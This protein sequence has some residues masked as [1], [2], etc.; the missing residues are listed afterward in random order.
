MPLTDPL[1]DP[2]QTG[3]VWFSSTGHTLRR[4][5]LDYWN[6]Y[7]GLAQ[8]G[9][10]LTE[11]FFES[12]GADNKLYLVQYFERSRFEMHSEN[13]GTRYEVL[14]GALGRDFHALAPPAPQLPAPARY[15]KETG[16][17]L[18]G[19]FKS[20]W[21]AHGGLAIHGYPITEQVQEKSQTDGNLYTVQYFERSRFEL[22]P[23]KS[24]S[25]HEVL[26]GLLGTQ[27]LVHN[28]YFSGAYP[29]YGHATDF[30]WVTG[31]MYLYGSPLCSGRTC[32]CSLVR[33]EEENVYSKLQLEGQSWHSR[34]NTLTQPQG[35]LLLVLGHLA[36]PGE[37]VN[38]CPADK[39]AQI[40]VVNYAQENP[41]P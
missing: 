8:F 1:S 37:A 14:R 24:G 17:N 11:E 41:L 31:L 30:S 21:S 22:H 38:H 12:V 40:Y 28:G 10:P 39:G 7:G 4:A 26:L 35:K 5:F 20:Y 25:Q 2:E 3:V 16:H 13:A 33:Y 23:E 27:K 36:G 9:Y 32:G 6:K 15:F 19:A 18:S 29:R 34:T